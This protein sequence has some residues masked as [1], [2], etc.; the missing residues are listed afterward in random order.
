MA[1][2]RNQFRYSRE[3]RVNDD[4]R[5]PTEYEYF[6]ESDKLADLKGADYF[7]EIADIQKNGFPAS[8]VKVGNTIKALIL[9]DAGSDFATDVT[10][11]ILEITAISADRKITVEDWSNSTA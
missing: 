8:C 10:T 6:H 11:V 1:F 7:N 5:F 2:E 3:Q 9:K 4:K